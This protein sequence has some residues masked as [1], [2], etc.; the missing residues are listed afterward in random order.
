MHWYLR[1]LR[2]YAVFTGRAGRPEFW[3][4]ALVH[5]LISVALALLDYALHSYDPARGV[6]LFGGAYALVSLLPA[7]GVA[8]R[9]LH[10]GNRRG[11][12]LLLILLPLLGP[13]VLLF[14]A[15]GAGDPGDNRFGPP[16]QGLR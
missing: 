1:V 3:W 9:R 15:L 6:G 2:R 13:L 11:W 10:D 14:F 16:A 12:W 8:V 7:A 5:S 4:F